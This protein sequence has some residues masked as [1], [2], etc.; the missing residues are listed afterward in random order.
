[1]RAAW[2]LPAIALALSLGSLLSCAPGPAA[3]RPPIAPGAATPPPPAMQAELRAALN[4]VL[5]ARGLRLDAQGRA[6]DQATGKA[7]SAV[8]A[9]QY[10]TPQRTD[11]APTGNSSLYWLHFMRGDYDSNGEVNISDLTTVGQHFGK[12]S[13]SPDWVTAAH[14]ADGDGNGEI[15]IADVTPIGMNFGAVIGAYAIEAREAAGEWRDYGA[16]DFAQGFP[17]NNT[18]EY[19][20]LCNGGMLEAEYRIRPVGRV[21]EFDWVTYELTDTGDSENHSALGIVDGRP[22]VAY[23]SSEQ[24]MATYLGFA[25]AT[26]ERPLSIADWHI[27]HKFVP[28][29]DLTIC[30]VPVS[31]QGRPALSYVRFDAGS[32][33]ENLYFNLR[34]SGDAAAAAWAE[35]IITGPAPSS[36][37]TVTVVRE[38]RPAVFYNGNGL[39]MFQ[40]ATSF[41]SSNADWTGFNCGP[42]FNEFREPSVVASGPWL[43]AS[44]ANTA[45]SAELVYSHSIAPVVSGPASFSEYS[46]WPGIDPNTH[47]VVLLS[48]GIPCVIAADVTQQA[49]QFI[50]GASREV[51]SS[52]N[53]FLHSVASS[54]GADDYWY[55]EAALIEGRPAITSGY[56]DKFLHWTG[57]QWPDSEDDWHHQALPPEMGQQPVALAS[58]GGLPILSYSRAEGSG[59]AELVIAVAVEQ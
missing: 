20:Y 42:A 48:G 46:L 56:A 2:T 7:V 25:V 21:R 17:S 10:A 13:G 45:P 12:N 35:H 3:N 43:F 26:V 57:G 55:P 22:M 4:R 50:M 47:P 52:A 8:P 18:L 27:E 53:W 36:F 28:G 6:V 14:V 31:I 59:P 37:P 16:M 51:D 30:P 9:Q 19:G 39:A 34:S 15:N 24:S 54:P 23:T 5:A 38:G 32:A 49:L 11:D 29:M 41:P 33:A 40:A 58:A 44:G 1:M